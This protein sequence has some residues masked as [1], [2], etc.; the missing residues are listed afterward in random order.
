MFSM[1]VS[2]IA[3][4][5]VTV[6]VTGGYVTARRFVGQRLRFVDA[7][8][9]PAAPWIAA[10]GAWVLGSLAALLLPFVGAFAA[11]SFG[12]AVGLGVSAGARDARSGT[13]W[14]TSGR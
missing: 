9:R 1:L 6:A 8:Q 3:F 11:L 14:L 5:V 4:L 10:T 2:L 12:V 7:V 13:N